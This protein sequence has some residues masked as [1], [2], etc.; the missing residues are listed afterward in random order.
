M[1]LE[2]SQQIFEKYSNINFHE[3]PP[4]DSR[5]FPNG[6]TDR[7]DMTKL[8]VGFRNFANTPRMGIKGT[9]YKEAPPEVILNLNLNLN[10]KI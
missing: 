3:N 9:Q 10:F 6:Q 8:I 1:K 4:S 7:H 5:V 2:F